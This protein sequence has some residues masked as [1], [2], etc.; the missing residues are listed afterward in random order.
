MSFA[1]YQFAILDL[2]T[3]GTRPTKDRITEIGLLQI[4]AG[5]VTATWSQLL[6]PETVIPEN[7][8]QITGITPGLIADK[9]VFDEVSDTLFELLDERI[10]VAHNAR[11]DYAFLKNS[12]KRCGYRFSPRILCSVKLSRLL[13]PDL[14]SHKLDYLI[15]HYALHN[16]QR[17]R[18][19]NDA[20]A[21]WDLIKL[22]IEQHGLECVTSAI[23]QVLK[24]SS[25]PVHLDPQEID[26]IPDKPGVYRFYG[27]NDGLLYIGK[28]VR[29][30]TR[31]KS[32]FAADYSSSKE[33]E[34]AK[35]VRRIAYDRTA[36]DISAQLLESAL[37]K[38]YQPLYNKRLRKHQRLAYFLLEKEK[39]GYLQLSL[40]WSDKL[41]EQSAGRIIG[42]F[43]SKRSAQDKLREWAKEHKLC[44]RLLGLEKKK[45]GPCFAY[46]L[47]QCQGACCGN[48][49]SDSYNQRLLQVV[50]DWFVKIWPY[51]G[52]VIYEEKADDM[53]TF[54]LIDQWCH[55]DMQDS[56][57]IL[58][59]NNIKTYE[60]DYDAYKLLQ[61][62]F[63]TSE[64]CHIREVDRK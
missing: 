35:Q 57:E 42:L 25:L 44:Q 21:I 9:P 28:S 37:I 7:I 61:K 53:T 49:S 16:L 30:K 11:F 55:L 64:P 22:W 51:N 31:V 24:T 54:H 26:K 56:Q 48:E 15:K 20:S 46:Q 52:P 62:A 19:M 63:I 23:E 60:F 50:D 8:Q 10:F 27:E 4:E 32:H 34:L 43:R 58:L 40:K 17:H 29:L 36:G 39:S 12:F 2:E 6:N 14:P 47:R 3:T 33:M 38:K 41:P 45:S 18:A 1:D 13:N 5:T 59:T